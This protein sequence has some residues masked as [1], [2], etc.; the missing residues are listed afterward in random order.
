M[1][2]LN[3]LGVHI[4]EKTGPLMWETDLLSM[5][6]I[7][8]LT[9]KTLHGPVHLY[10]NS[11]YKYLLETWGI[12]HIYDKIDTELLDNK[13]IN[14]D[15]KKYWAFSKLLIIEQIKDSTPFTVFDTDLWFL[16]ALEV[17]ETCDMMMYHLEKFDIKHPHNVYIDFDQMVPQSIKEMNFDRGILPTNA[18]IMHFNNNEFIQEWIDLSKEVAIFNNNLTFNHKSAQ[19][20][21]VEQRLLPMLL[22]KRNLK[23]STFV[24]NVYRTDKMDSQDGSEWEPHLN[25]CSPKSKSKFEIIKHVWGLKNMFYD[26]ILKYYVMDSVIRTL[27]Q[28]PI[29][30]QPYFKLWQKV[31]E[32]QTLLMKE[33]NITGGTLNQN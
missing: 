31:V 25:S 20:C 3:N 33:L 26:K 15:F 27:N 8:A 29:M 11:E 28:F 7:S 14:I 2:T 6:L 21:F 12:D 22:Q 5:N 24:D 23:Y 1:K 32:D 4:F 19:M 9:W 13:S 17:D 10:C 18:A 16:D 30:E